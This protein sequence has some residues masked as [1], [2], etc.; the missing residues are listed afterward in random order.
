MALC[1]AAPV[2]R[3][4]SDGFS[5]D[6]CPARAQGHRDAEQAVEVPIMIAGGHFQRQSGCECSL[7]L[8][9]ES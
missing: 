7:R 4:R 8:F 1:I 6:W 3:A 2:A 5:N 9:P